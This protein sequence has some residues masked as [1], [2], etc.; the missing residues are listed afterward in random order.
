MGIDKV[1]VRTKTSRH[2]KDRSKCRLFLARLSKHIKLDS[3]KK[4]IAIYQGEFL[5]AVVRRRT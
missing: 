2:N 4:D 1:K 3:T 5:T